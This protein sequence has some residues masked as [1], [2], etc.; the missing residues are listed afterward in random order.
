MYALSFYGS[1]IIL[2][3]PNNFGQVPIVLNASNSF[4]AGSN[5]AFLAFPVGMGLH[6]LVNWSAGPPVSASLVFGLLL[7]HKKI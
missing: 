3:R 6:D 4:W 2:D 1:K 5:Y 7:I